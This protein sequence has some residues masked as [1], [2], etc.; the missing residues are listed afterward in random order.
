MHFCGKRCGNENRPQKMSGPE[1]VL[2]ATDAFGGMSSND[3]RVM[4]TFTPVAWVKASISLTKASSSDCTK[5]FQRSSESCAPFSGFHGAAWAQAFAHSRSPEPA[6]APVAATAVPPCMRVRRVNVVMVASSLFSSI[7]SFSGRLVE[8]M[9]EPWIGLEPDLVA[10]LEFEALAEHR[11][12]VLAAELGDDLKLGAGRLHHLDFGLGAV[13][14][15]G[16]ML[17]ADAVDGGPAVGTR[18]RSVEGERDPVWPGE[19]GRT[20]EA[21]RAAQEIHR[22]RADEARDE[23]VVR[24]VIELERRTNLL[25]QPV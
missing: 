4:L 23:Q 6:R 7:Q 2:A 1:P 22:R 9:H 18:R 11:D 17:G 15:D 12:D 14:G 3:S 20:I 24:P 16:E 5:Y 21:D 8:Q 10:R 19:R 25:D 13:V